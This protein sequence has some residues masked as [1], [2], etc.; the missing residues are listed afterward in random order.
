MAEIEDTDYASTEKVI[1]EL[2][3]LLQQFN[4]KVYEQES[5]SLTIANLTLESV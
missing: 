2:S 5:V 1:I 3:Q 4:A